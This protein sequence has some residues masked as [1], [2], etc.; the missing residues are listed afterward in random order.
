MFLLLFLLFSICLCLARFLLADSKASFHWLSESAARL[1]AHREICIR[2]T[3]ASGRPSWGQPLWIF[4]GWFI[5]WWD[6]AQYFQVTKS[7]PAVSCFLFLFYLLCK[8][9]TYLV[10]WLHIIILYC[11][12][13]SLVYRPHNIPSP[14]KNYIYECR[15]KIHISGS[16][17][18]SC[19]WPWVSPG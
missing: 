2:V 8:M 1:G 9:K 6:L 15:I 13:Q 19:H 18:S 5:I 4:V 16:G 17:I 11:F 14:G 12:Y 7:V 10:W 3:G